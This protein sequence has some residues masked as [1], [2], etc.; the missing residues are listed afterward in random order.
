MDQYKSVQREMDNI[1]NNNSWQVYVA[2]E[3]P[4][5]QAETSC[6]NIDPLQVVKHEF[7]ASEV[8]RKCYMSVRAQGPTLQVE[9][10][11]EVGPSKSLPAVFDSRESRNAVKYEMSVSP[12][13]FDYFMDDNVGEPPVQIKIK[14][15]FETF[16]NLSFPDFSNKK[17]CMSPEVSTRNFNDTNCDYS[18]VN[19]LN[20][21]KHLQNQINRKTYQCTHCNKK[22]DLEGIL[23]EHMIM[24]IGEK[25]YQCSYCEKY[26]SKKNNLEKHQTL[27]IQEKPFK[28]IHCCKK[29]SQ[30]TR[31]VQNHSLTQK[32]FLVKNIKT[33]PEKKIYQCIHCEKVFEFETWLRRHLETHTEQKPYQCSQCEK[34]FKSK[35]I[36]M[37]HVQIHTGVKQHQCSQCNKAFPRKSELNNHLRTHTEKK[38]Y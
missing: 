24:L 9:T 31:L 4:P 3:D 12:E 32:S 20:F 10:K 6:D 7:V 11:H 23:V 2:T 1:R 26:F 36:L 22:F 17:M 16:S 35:Q 33:N 13:D 38:T 29:V 25:P 30:V 14:Q 28:C 18:T 19:L 21:E 8:D 5:I 15:E 37:R 27:H 34:N